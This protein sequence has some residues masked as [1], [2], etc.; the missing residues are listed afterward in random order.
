VL[1]VFQQITLAYTSAAIKRK[2][3]QCTD[4]LDVVYKGSGLLTLV[5]IGS[6]SAM[7]YNAKKPEHQRI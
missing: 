2:H 1:L 4:G 7:H 6:D 5:A 3:L